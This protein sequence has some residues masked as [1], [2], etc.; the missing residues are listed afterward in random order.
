MDDILSKYI[1][2]PKN[3]ELEVRFKNIDKVTVQSALDAI[4][5]NEMSYVFTAFID[6][7]DYGPDTKY[8]IRAFYT[9]GVVTDRQPF[10][11]RSVAHVKDKS[12]NIVLSEETEDTSISSGQLK[13]KKVIMK[14]RISTTVVGYESWRVDID[15]IHELDHAVQ[16]VKKAVSNFIKITDLPGLIDSLGTDRYT[17]RIE[18]EHVGPV[19]AHQPSVDDIMDAT[20]LLSMLSEKDTKSSLLFGKKMKRIAEILYPDNET[21]RIKKAHSPCLK[22]MVSGVQSLTYQEYQKM[23]PPTDFMITSKVDGYRALILIID[24]EAHMIYKRNSVKTLSMK[25]GRSSNIGIVLLEG[26]YIESSNLFV[27]FD[28]IHYGKTSLISKPL[29]A[30]LE[31]MDEA[32]KLLS[33]Y[34]RDLNIET[35]TYVGLN[36]ESEYKKIITS[37][38]NIG[39]RIP[40]DGLILTRKGLPYTKSKIYKWKPSHHQTIDFYCKECPESWYNDTIYQRQDGKKLYFLYNGI[41]KQLMRN[42]GLLPHDKYNIL[43]P[44][45]ADYAKIPIQFSIPMTPLSYLF[46]HDEDATSLNN[47]IV[48]LSVGSNIYITDRSNTMIDWKFIKT[49]DDKMCTNGQDYGNAYNTALRTL[50]NHIEPFPI[51]YLYMPSIAIHKTITPVQ[52]YMSYIKNVAISEYSKH[53]K[54]IMDIGMTNGSD[55]LNYMRKKASSLTVV[56]VDKANI[57]RIVERWIDLSDS[58]LPPTSLKAVVVDINDDV[59]DNM[60]KILPIIGSIRYDTIFA[61]YV[62]QN[63]TQTVETIRNLAMFCQRLTEKKAKI[64]I[65]VLSGK[66]IHELGDWKAIEHGQVKYAIERRYRDDQLLNANQQVDIT[67]PANGSMTQYLV[68]IDHLTEVFHEQSMNLIAHKSALDYMNGFQVH[69]S[70]KYEQLT[71]NDK[72]YIGLYDVIVYERK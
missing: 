66:K 13:P 56:D 69:D 16:A 9:N 36:N 41:H 19:T 6:L 3:K 30:R 17:Y 15:V 51:E 2:N 65:I 22:Y 61:F 55:L 70:N 34:I 62:V 31:Y 53:S 7:L 48:E 32:M 46:Y 40:T 49:R 12:Y 59:S 25:P 72:K 58:S 68:N 4:V 27:L 5:K 52:K 50:L 54:H 28:V 35:A 64:C 37:M 44:D 11:K 42:I 47:M 63:F 60:A 8:G 45:T 18:A 24:S 23:F 29:E 10:K 57:V 14:Y 39:D 67:S 20:T 38:V 33:E 26:E 71:D 43:F 1:N 21:L